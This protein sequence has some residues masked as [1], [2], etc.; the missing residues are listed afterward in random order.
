MSV[1]R[2]IIPWFPF[3]WVRHITRPCITPGLRSGRGGQLPYL[4]R[5]TIREQGESGTNPW[6]LYLHNFLARDSV[7]FHNHPSHWSFSLVLWG[8]Y[9]E[10]VFIP[11]EIAISMAGE[12]MRD[13]EFVPGGVIL[14]RHVRWFNWIPASKYHRITTLHPGP[15]AR[16]VWTLFLCGPLTGK[17]WGFWRAGVGHVDH[18]AA[19]H[20]KVVRA[21]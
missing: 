15:G 18:T 21:D 4:D 14:C 10:E 9:T 6:R 19:E 5:Y 12:W 13:V 1:L 20:T 8:S 7:E 2:R 17:G 16:G 11:E 3:G